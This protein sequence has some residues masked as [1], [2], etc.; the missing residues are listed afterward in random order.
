[1]S[2]SPAAEYVLAVGG[3]PGRLDDFLKYPI[4]RVDFVEMDPKLIETSLAVLSAGDSAL[5][6]SDRVRIVTRDGRRFIKLIDSPEYDLVVLNLSEPSTASTNRYYTKEFFEELK[7]VL[8]PGGT[9]ALSLPTS[10]G[11]VSRRMK[12]AN[13]SIYNSLRSVFEHV[14]ASTEEYGLFLAS[15]APVDISPEHLMDN[16]VKSGVSAEYFHPYIIED[17]FSPLRVDLHKERLGSVSAVNTDLRPAAYLYNLM[18]WAEMHGART[19]NA[20]LELGGYTVLLFFVLFIAIVPGIARNRKKTLYY[21]MFTTG[22]AAMAFTLAVLLGFQSLYG[23][24][25]EMFGLL[26]AV[27][28]VGMAAGSYL[29][30]RIGLRG[31]RVSRLCLRSPPCFFS[32]RSR[33]SIFTACLPV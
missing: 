7:E 25:Y 13:G 3:S 16:F 5:L 15:D 11:Y 10:A 22:Y 23:Y 21:S 9:V 26:S 19:L 12:L 20:A 33:C 29:M 17:A 2:A 24:V 4:K 18:L 8:R 27:F 28:M 6:E 32:A 14:E 1:M 30:R 31:L